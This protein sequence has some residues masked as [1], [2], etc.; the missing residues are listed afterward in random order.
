ML[1]KNE[2]S[3]DAPLVVPTPPAATPQVDA[4]LLYEQQKEI[5][6]Q[7]QEQLKVLTTEGAT[8]ADKIKAAEEAQAKVDEAMAT[9][10]AKVKEHVKQDQAR[11]DAL[12][13]GLPEPAQKRLKPIKDKL[14]L[15]T[16]IAYLEE[17]KAT[18][19]TM[20]TGKPPL[21]GSGRTG[22]SAE[23]VPHAD[24]IDTLEQG[25]GMDVKYLPLM[26]V[27]RDPMKGFTASMPLKENNK[28]IRGQ[29][30]KPE[31]M[32][33]EHAMDRGEPPEVADPGDLSR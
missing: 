3:D 18:A 2:V 27:T 4:A 12:Y 9:L 25:L 10:D 19:S 11:A 22:R 1:K 26:N 14:D 7:L 20:G 23:F 28:L 8:Q 13:A 31:P 17:E 21:R 24:T 15:P 29:T 30:V 16:W 32:T 6:K 33:R 5:T